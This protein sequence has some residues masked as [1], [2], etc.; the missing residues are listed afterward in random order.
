MP[1]IPRLSH[2]PSNGCIAGGAVPKV[3][4]AAM[5]TRVSRLAVWLLAIALL[6]VIGGAVA[7]WVG[8]RPVAVPQLEVYGLVPDF[9]LKERAGRTVTRAEL[10]GKVSVVN[11]FYTRC[12]DTCPLQSAH[13]ARLQAELN[14]RNLRFVSITVDP[15]Y[16]TIAV[17]GAYAA[18]FHAD[19]GRWL[20]LTG[21]RAA[22]YALAVNGF[23]LAAIVSRAPAFRP[24][25]TWAAPTMA[26]AHDEAAEPKIIQL[27]HGSRFA[28]VDRHARIRGYFD[29]TDWDAVKRMRADLLP[30]LTE[31]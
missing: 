8:W 28:V 7:S 5:K 26:W 23:H 25:W 9:S 31:R 15:D 30:L 2:A 12:P 3:A 29:G 27:V 17:L 11:F 13:L 18:R 14:A 22:I 1:T 21:P 16:D 20:F 19:P 10:L 4:N 6:V 24:A